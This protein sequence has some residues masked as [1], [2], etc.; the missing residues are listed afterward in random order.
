MYLVTLVK[1]KS[2]NNKKECK[3]SVWESQLNWLNVVS[4]DSQSH[5]VSKY[6]VHFATMSQKSKKEHT[7]NKKIRKSSSVVISPFIV[8]VRSGWQPEDAGEIW[9]YH[10]KKSRYPDASG[11]AVN[12]LNAWHWCQAVTLRQWNTQHSGIKW[13]P[14]VIPRHTDVQAGFYLEGSP[15]FTAR[16]WS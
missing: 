2:V 10:A 13:K 1:I 8:F 12:P 14:R 15:E 6:L 16:V 9:I 4:P 11:S 7:R 5:L 3:S